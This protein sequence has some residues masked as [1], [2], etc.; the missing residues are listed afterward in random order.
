MRSIMIVVADQTVLARSNR[1]RRD[2]WGVWHKLGIREEH[3][4]FWRGNLMGRHRFES[5]EVH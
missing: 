5:A 4:E 3:G 2:G 1:G